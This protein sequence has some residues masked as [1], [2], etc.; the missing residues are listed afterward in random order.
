MDAHFHGHDKAF[1]NALS[2]KE[3]TPVIPA[4]A[5]IQKELNSRNQEAVNGCPF[6]WA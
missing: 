3:R 5:G 4:K 2:G 1:L 6:S